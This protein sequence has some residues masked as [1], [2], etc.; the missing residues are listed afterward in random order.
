MFH[1]AIRARAHCLPVSVFIRPIR[2]FF[3]TFF[4]FVELFASIKTPPPFPRYSGRHIQTKRKAGRQTGKQVVGASHCPSVHLF[5]CLS[6]CL[7]VCLLLLHSSSFLFS[8][9]IATAIATATA[10]ATAA[11]LRT[12]EAKTELHYD[13]AMLRHTHGCHF[14]PPVPT[15][16]ACTRCFCPGQ[17]EEKKRRE[18]TS[19]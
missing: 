4:C 14:M 13:D 8:S 16:H 7:S 2:P 19:V 10:T 6:V 9:A 3:T 17:R 1:L 15:T 12:Y 5:V 18:S 11:K